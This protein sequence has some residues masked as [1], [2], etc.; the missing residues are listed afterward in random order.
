MKLYGVGVGPGDSKDVTVGVV[1]ILNN[2][3]V[4]FVPVKKSG[5]ESAAYK[6][7]KEY[8]KDSEIV[9]LVFP[10]NYNKEQLEKQWE[11]N[12]RI[13]EN[14][15][16]ENKTGTII[17]IGDISLYSTAMYIEEILK[18]KDIDIV[19]KPGITS[20]SKI[21]SIL[22]IHLAKWEEGLAVVPAS[23][24]SSFNLENILKNFENVVVMKPS[25]NP[26]EIISAL[27]NNNL[28]DCFKL[29]VK[30]GTEEERIVDNLEELKNGIPYLST[31][32]IKKT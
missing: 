25:H 14:K 21:A 5:V 8:I 22:G 6:V 3:P 12:A 24:D 32:I 17:T 23:R 28:Q 4:I 30:A 9:E 11:E 29:V 10:M 7:V 27:K 15:L 18:D 13:I 31:M 16:K 1:E 19:L 2:S 26:E 20:Y